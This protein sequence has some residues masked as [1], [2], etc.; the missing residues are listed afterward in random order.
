MWNSTK[1]SGVMLSKFSTS[2]YHQLAVG[3]CPLRGRKYDLGLEASGTCRFGCLDKETPEHIL[4]KCK[5][6]K[7]QQKEIRE[8]CKNNGIYYTLNS[9]LTVDKLKILVEKL[10]MKVF[11]TGKVWN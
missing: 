11:M 2:L 7:K 8:G 9:I 5:F 6:L 1:I 4:L 3:R 10:L